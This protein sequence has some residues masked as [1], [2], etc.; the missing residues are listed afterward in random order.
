MKKIVLILCVFILFGCASS[1]LIRSIPDGAKV[2]QEGVVLGLTPFDYWDRSVSFAEK[3]FT[4][5]RDGYKDKDIVIRK[6][7]FYISRLFSPPILAL[8]WLFGYND[9]YFFELEKCGASLPGC[10][11]LSNYRCWEKKLDEMP[12]QNTTANDISL[13]LGAPPIR[14]EEVEPTK[15][16]TKSEQCYWELQSG[17][18]ASSTGGGLVNIYGG[19]AVSGS[20]A[21]YQRY[22]RASCRINDG[23]LVKCRCNWQE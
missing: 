7:V 4:L 5:Q 9:L 6:D 21:A 16:V 18:Y 12:K 15:G 13:M 8:P 2:K 11:G 20:A 23:Y 14:C 17:H 19:A 1:T 10:E 3:K 22:F